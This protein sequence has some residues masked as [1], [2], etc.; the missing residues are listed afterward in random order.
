MSVLN[1]DTLL[2]EERR[3]G[4]SMRHTS[5]QSYPAVY[6]VAMFFSIKFLFQFYQAMTEIRYLW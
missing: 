5:F 2:N 4:R 1:V 3:E 6:L